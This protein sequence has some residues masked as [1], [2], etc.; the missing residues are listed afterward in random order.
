MRKCIAAKKFFSDLLLAKTMLVFAI[1]VVCKSSQCGQE[2]KA[3][4]A[5]LLFESLDFESRLP[6]ERSETLIKY[7]ILGVNQKT[8][9]IS[10]EL[11]QLLLD[12]MYVVSS[13]A[14]KR[15]NS[16]A[17]EE[18]QS[19]RPPK[20]VCSRGRTMTKVIMVVL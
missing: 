5:D 8:F 9:E 7:L 13:T 17:D 16:D 2:H 19:Q 4:C 1:V 18:V 3:A 12:I 14:N 20:A 10:L 15:Q 11:C 6:R